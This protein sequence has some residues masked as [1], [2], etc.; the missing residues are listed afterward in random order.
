MDSTF[1]NKIPQRRLFWLQ[2]LNARS[3]MFDSV[4]L[5]PADKREGEHRLKQCHQE[6]PRELDTPGFSSLS[7][8]CH[9]QMSPKYLKYRTPHSR[10]G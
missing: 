7:C 4:R 6:V 9:S 2:T 8:Q 1:I 5:I 10:E 3:L